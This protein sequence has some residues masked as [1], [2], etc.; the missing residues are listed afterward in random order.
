MWKKEHGTRLEVDRYV[1]CSEQFAGRAM[2][3]F[4]CIHACVRGLPS[5]DGAAAGIYRDNGM[6]LSSTR[7]MTLILS[8]GAKRKNV[9]RT[10]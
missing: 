7:M 5:S 10:E 8:L 2:W 6:A 3:P 1:Q 9:E 4:A